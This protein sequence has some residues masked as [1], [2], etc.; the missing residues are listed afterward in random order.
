M[1]LMSEPKGDKNRSLGWPRKGPFS[2]LW[3]AGKS[4]GWG[5]RDWGHR[6]YTESAINPSRT[7]GKVSCGGAQYLLAAPHPAS[8]HHHPLH[9]TQIHG[10]HYRG[11]DW[12]PGKPLICSFRDRRKPP[13]HDGRCVF[14]A[15]SCRSGPCT[16]T[17]PKPPLDFPPLPLLLHNPLHATTSLPY[18][19][20][21]CPPHAYTF[22][23]L[24]LDQK[25][26]HFWAI[27][28]LRFLSPI[29]SVVRANGCWRFQSVLPMS[30]Q[31]LRSTLPL[32]F[33]FLYNP[34]FWL[35]DF[36]ACHL[37]SRCFLARLIFRPWRWKRYVPP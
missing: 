24:F 34:K 37:L 1:A 31:E 10:T 13:E 19:S 8:Q 20:A 5:G 25:T 27:P 4:V 30:Q 22:S 18:L 26:S 7:S 14:S 6:K 21:P 35:A 33:C 29:G 16:L 15:G 32:P 11:G 2:G 17:S 3:K 23:R 28:K 36:S 9:Q 12:A